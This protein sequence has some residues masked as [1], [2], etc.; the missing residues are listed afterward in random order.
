MEERRVQVIKG[1]PDRWCFRDTL[2]A[3]G[4]GLIVLGCLL[5]FP[6]L[7]D[8]GGKAEDLLGA[9]TLRELAFHGGTATAALVLAAIGLVA[10]VAS[11]FVAGPD[12]L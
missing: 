8:G 6:L 2:R 12:E 10:L 7:G 1:D 9:D 3:I 11:L 5:I 4:A